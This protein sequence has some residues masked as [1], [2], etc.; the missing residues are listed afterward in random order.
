[1]FCVSDKYFESTSNKTFTEEWDEIWVL[2][3]KYGYFCMVVFIF[4]FLS[5]TN[6]IWIGGLL[7]TNRRLSLP[8][9]LNLVSGFIGILHV[10]LLTLDLGLLFGGILLDSCWKSTIFAACIFAFALVQVYVVLTGSVLRFIYL[11]YPM[12]QVKRKTVYLALF[13][14]FVLSF[15][16][17]AVFVICDFIEMKNFEKIMPQGLAIV[18]VLT[19]IV[20]AVL[21][22]GLQ[23]ALSRATVVDKKASQRHT[24]AVKRLTVLNVLGIIL[25]LP[26]AVVTFYYT[27]QRN[28]DESAVLLE[29]LVA[30]SWAYFVMTLYNGFIPLIHLVWNKKI[31]RYYSSRRPIVNRDISIQMR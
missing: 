18:V 12:K 30:T 24:K 19:S 23:V 16:L 2:E 10:L 8:Q 5:L 14:E 4:V 27:S 21:I 17:G 15:G 20:D 31:R 3:F 9:R 13:M 28:L 7:K 1:M 6:S 11:A 26:L 22:A 29:M 25:T